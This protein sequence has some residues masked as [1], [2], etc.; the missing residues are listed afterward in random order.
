[1][2]LDI[3]CTIFMGLD[4]SEEARDFV[5][6]YDKFLEKLNSPADRERLKQLQPKDA[7]GDSIFNELREASHRF[8]ET[9]TSAFFIKETPL[10]DFTRKYGVF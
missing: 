9:L 3:V 8:Q 1:M 5:D 4:L 10:R 2:L 6:V 7:Y